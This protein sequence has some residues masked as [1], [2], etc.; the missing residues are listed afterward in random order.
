T[1]WMTLNGNVLIWEA[2]D[3]VTGINNLQHDRVYGISAILQPNNKFGL[4]IGYDYNDVFSQILICYIAGPAP[5]GFAPTACVAPLIQQLSVYTST[6]QYGYF[7]AS[8]TP[9]RRFTAHLGANLTGN[10]GSAL[11][12]NPNAVSGPLDS[13]WLHPYGGFEYKFSK[14]WTGKAFWDYYGY[15]EDPTFGIGGEAVQDIYAPRNFRGNLYTLSLKY[16]F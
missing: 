12:I 14:E 15:H 2:R 16:A 13:K 10:S 3:N 5:S 9:V 4:E 1:N 7:D 11:L 8:W 6:S